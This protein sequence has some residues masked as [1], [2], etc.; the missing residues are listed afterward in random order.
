[1]NQN[2]HSEYN[3]RMIYFVN[4]LFL[5]LLLKKTYK[6]YNLTSQPDFCFLFYTIFLVPSKLK[7]TIQNNI[8]IHKTPKKHK[9]LKSHPSRLNLL[10]ILFLYFY[11]SIS[12]LYRILL[13]IW[14]FTLSTQSLF[15][16][17][18][19]SLSLTLE[20]N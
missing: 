15:L 17:L 1:M 6:K 10:C 4:I 12:P 14:F 8:L 11:L 16:S 7:F 2:K 19:L 5:L 3:N 18:S 13:T 9:N 20:W